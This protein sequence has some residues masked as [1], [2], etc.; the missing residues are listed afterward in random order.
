MAIVTV[1]VVDETPTDD[2]WEMPENPVS[3]K[4]PVPRAIITFNGSDAIAAKS[5]GDL[6]NYNLICRPPSG[7]VY[8]V[9]TF[10]LRFVSDD[11]VER[12]NQ[13]G[14][15]IVSDVA[16]LANNKFFNIA[17][18]G[19]VVFA[20]ALAVR[21][22]EPTSVTPKNFFQGGIEDFRLIV[23]DMDSSASTAGNMAYEVEFYQYDVDQLAKWE[24]NTPIPVISFASF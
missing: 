5:A 20:A 16:G 17:S 7:F 6:T 1:T 9:R 22:W 14:I 13:F 18:P 24:L 2:R 4:S 23:Q 10:G 8:L 15:G 12:F 19:Q 11:L 21:I 3:L